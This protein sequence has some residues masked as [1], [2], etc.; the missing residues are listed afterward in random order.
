MQTEGGLG[1]WVC[2][3]VVVVVV[4]A[5]VSGG[6]E[7]HGKGTPC[8]ICCLI[9]MLWRSRA[10]MFCVLLCFFAILGGVL[11]GCILGRLMGA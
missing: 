10:Y 3:W 4:V 2:G 1:G 7:L 6:G 9:Y 11:F 8:C 5:V